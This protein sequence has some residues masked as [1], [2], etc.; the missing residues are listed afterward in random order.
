MTAHGPVRAPPRG[1]DRP[2]GDR[3]GHRSV[4]RGM[5]SSSGPSGCPTTATAGRDRGRGRIGLDRSVGDSR[6][7]R[8]ATEGAATAAA[9]ARPAA[10]PP[11][12][13]DVIEDGDASG[14]TGRWATVDRFGRRLKARRPEGAT[15]FRLPPEGRVRTTA[16]AA[17]I[18]TPPSSAAGTRWSSWT[19]RPRRRETRNVTTAP[20][21]GGASLPES[22]AGPAAAEPSARGRG[23]DRVCDRR[24]DAG[25][26]DNRE[27]PPALVD[28]RSRSRTPRRRA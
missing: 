5:S 25:A 15:G 6:P 16:L 9:P 12:R 8:A 18:I 27:P 2:A 19:S 13:R 4:L 14:S 28:A 24:C 3:G 7:L 26:A 21:P 23:K 22:L 11:R 20:P 1:S 17:G 10:R